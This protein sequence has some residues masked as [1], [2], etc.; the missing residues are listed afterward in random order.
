MI[1]RMRFASITVTDIG[2]AKD[3]YVSKLGFRLLVETPLPGGN[4]FVMVAP[5]GGGSSL[6]FSMPMPGQEHIG[7][8]S[9]AFET[10]DVRLTYGDLVAKGVAFP[11]PPADTPW[12][13][14]EAVFADPFGNN[15]MLQQ[16]GI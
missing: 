2:A 16:G 13:G 6:V 8:S 7:V 3:F 12:G 1:S 5:A 15:F 14:V 9:I 11:K 4:Q 10:D